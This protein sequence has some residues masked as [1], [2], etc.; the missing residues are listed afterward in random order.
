MIYDNDV[1]PEMI[2]CPMCNTVQGAIVEKAI[3]WG[4]FVHICCECGYVIME[5]E[6]IEVKPFKS[7]LSAV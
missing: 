4:S 3:P 6:W 1:Y 2:E 5:S 7:K